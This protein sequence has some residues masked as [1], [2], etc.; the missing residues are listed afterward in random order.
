MVD[1]PSPKACPKCGG[2]LRRIG[3]SNATRIDW[4]RGHFVRVEVRRPS[5]ACDT[6][7]V[8]ETAPEPG[9]FALPRSIAANGLLAHIIIDKYADNIPLNR[10]VA[11]FARSGFD[12]SLST[13]CDLV[14][15]TGAL[16]HRLINVM[17]REQVAGSWIQ[18]DDTGLPV[19]DGTPGQTGTGRL[20]VYVGS[21]HVVYRFTSTKQGAG[22]AKHIEGFRGVLLVDGGSEFNE[23]IRTMGLTRAGCWS[24]ARRYFHDAR[25]SSQALADEA[26]RRIGVLFE[27]ER[28]IRDADLETRRTARTTETRLALDHV[29]Q[30]LTEHA[31][32]VRPK[33]GIGQAIQYAQNQWPFLETCASHPEIPIHNN[34]SEL[35]LRR[36]VVGRKNW[37]FA[38]SEGGANTAATLFSLIGSC[39]LVDLDPW[40]YFEEVL[41]RINDHPVNRLDE[42]TPKALRGK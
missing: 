12:I 3:T 39:Q 17:H 13:L 9:N 26:I 25:D 20:W 38:G 2:S 31:S 32:G 14:R 6:C 11:R 24:H 34:S 19:L 18:A 15:G 36:P 4:R 1:V 8:V 35:Q 16:L 22:P 28:A 40:T 29:K 10:Q 41:G 7:K 42:L 37:L 5:C 33:S 30:W 21:G 27:I 23:A